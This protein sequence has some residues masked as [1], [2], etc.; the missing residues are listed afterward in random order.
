M[1][2]K[3]W[4]AKEVLKKKKK[5]GRKKEKTQSQRENGLLGAQNIFK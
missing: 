4:A 3:G 5:N 1:K 2:E